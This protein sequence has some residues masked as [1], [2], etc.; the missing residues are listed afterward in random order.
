MIDPSK[1]INPVFVE[2]YNKIIA[3]EFKF[4]HLWLLGGR[5]SGKSSFAGFLIPTILMRDAS[6]N[7]SGFIPDELLSNA[8]ILRKFG[9]T[10]RESVLEQ[11]ASA[12]NMLGVADFWERSLNPM[13]F[14]YKPTGQKIIFRGLDDATK[15]KSIKVEKGRI[16]VVWYEELEEFSG[17][18]EIRK[19]NQSFIRGGGKIAENQV[20]INPLIIYSYNPPR[21][22]SNWVNSEALKKVPSRFVIKSDYTTMPP[23]WLGREFLREALELRDTDLMSYKHEYLG[24]IVGVEGTIFKN[25][26]GR[27]ITDREIRSFRNCLQGLDWGFGHPAAFT[28]S[29]YDYKNQDL[30]IFGEVVEQG[31]TN[32]ELAAQI[33][34]QTKGDKRTQI[35]ADCEDMKSVQEFR[36]MGFNIISCRKH[37][38]LRGEVYGVKWLQKLKNIYI[39]E[40]RCP[41]TYKAF[42]GYAYKKDREGFFTD[43]LPDKGEDPIDS[44]R[45]ALQSFIYPPTFSA[46]K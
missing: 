4:T 44:V 15:T 34:K 36:R 6:W 45:Y 41:E 24:E 13:Q 33:K 23:E 26:K 1:L 39:D 40:S 10:L 17:M 31:L 37:K 19:A 38:G 8:V 14:T 2:A 7:K 46:R 35:I 22:I 27:R 28:Q 11:V 43:S 12:L 3:N 9:N 16:S 18:Q 42:C 29:Y 25:V 32:P 20:N 30:Y 21:T 5:G